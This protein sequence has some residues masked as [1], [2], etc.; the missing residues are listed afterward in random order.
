ML[1]SVESFQ[2]VVPH[3]TYSVGHIMLFVSLVLCAATSLRS[4]SRSLELL[5]SFF[6]LA[7][8]A[9]AWSSG[10]LWLLRLGYYKLSRPKEPAE[11][12]VWIV[13]HTVQM[14]VEKCLVILGIRLS[15]LPPPGQC[16][17]HEEVEPIGLYPVKHSSGEMVFEQLEEAVKKTGVPR[18]ILSDDG[19]DLQAG[20]KQFC[21]N[22]PESCAIYDIKHK[23]AVV[24]KHELEGEAAW[25]EFRQ[26]SSQTKQKVQQTPFAFLA[27]PSQRAKA[28]YM[29]LEGLVHWGS[30]LLGFLEHS[31]Q[32]LAQDWDPELLE[33]RFGWI[34]RFREELQGWS[35][36]LQVVEAAESFVRHQ[37]LYRGC[38]GELKKRLKSLMCTMRTRKVGR[39]LLAFVAAEALKATPKER[40]L[41]SSEVIES[42]FGKFKRLEQ[43]QAK[44][45]FTGLVLSI[46][47]MVSRTTTEVIQKALET[48]PTKTVLDWCKNTL[49]QSVQAQRKKAFAAQNQAEQNWDQLKKAA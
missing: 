9:P 35:E 11:D 13:D 34:R 32:G 30:K 45:G 41:G 29:N 42:V 10:R 31:P 19:P 26:C 18:E 15:S 47:A 37:G 38:Q 3:H 44:S 12:W 2:I 40:L 14:G 17:G 6:G 48:V 4:A 36:L 1:G 27:P 28:R 22:H 24:L 16:V 23:T 21:A 33:E 49:G 25:E 43:A 8:S 20:I 7:L 5:L 39:Q 46:S